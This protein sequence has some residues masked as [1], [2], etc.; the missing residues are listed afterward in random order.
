MKTPLSMLARSL[1]PLTCLLALAASGCAQDEVAR[2]TGSYG[3][4][5]ELVTETGV[6]RRGAT[7]RE[8]FAR[9]LL[10]DD[11]QGVAY[12]DILKTEF[13]IT[14]TS[15][16]A[17]PHMVRVFTASDSEVFT[18]WDG[19]KELESDSWCCD[20]WG[21]APGYGG[22][23]GVPEGEVLAGSSLKLG[24]PA[25]LSSTPTSHNGI[26]EIDPQHLSLL[27]G[28]WEVRREGTLLAGRF[29]LRSE[30]SDQ[31]STD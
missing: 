19:L 2:S 26:L 17:S 5:V 14:D 7:S 24:F 11:Y 10:S 25:A 30:Q 1:S 12:M 28:R 27:H 3:I 23:S 16:Q 21:E 6:V 18:T 20:P 8:D 29:V 22:A 31:G 13:D 15:E 4:G 9:L